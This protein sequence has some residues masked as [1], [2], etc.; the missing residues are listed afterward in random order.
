[1][2]HEVAVASLTGGMAP[3]PAPFVGSDRLHPDGRPKGAFRDS[4]RTVPDA[5]N[6]LAASGAVAFPLAVVAAAVV[7]SHPA[8]WVAAFLLMPIA[9]NRLFILHHEAAHR[10]LFSNRRLNDLIGINLVG[11]LTFG[12]GGHGYRVGHMNHHRD[13]F[14]PKEPDFGLYARYPITSASMRR[15]HRRDLTGVSA[16]RIIRPR[17]QRLGQ[18]HHRRLTY[19][20]LAGQALVLAAFWASGHP[21]LYLLLWVLPWATLYQ[22]LNRIR[23]IAEHGGMTRSGDRRRTTH[24]VHQSLAARMVMVPFSVGYHLAHHVDMTVPYR[25][26]PRLHRALVADGYLGELEWP[27]Y[28]S[29]WR[30]LRAD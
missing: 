24:H 8:A 28:R 4:L 14:G 5:R 23:A 11:W 29:L 27:T 30:A 6:A 15:K 3:T 2:E 10:V 1:M 9:Q 17:F 12:T 25:N 26:L 19:R 16:F 13:E 21:W 22:G 20:F 7:L 18:V